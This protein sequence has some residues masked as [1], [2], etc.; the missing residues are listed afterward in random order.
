MLVLAAGIAACSPA[1]ATTP[2]GSCPLSGC[3]SLSRGDQRL[4]TGV[5]TVDLLVEPDDG[6]SEVVK[7][8]DGAQH[9]ILVSI[10]ILSQHRIV[11]ALERAATQGVAVYVLLERHPFGLFQQPQDE[12]AQLYA[13]G[14]HV[15]WAPDSFTYS[16]AK[17]MVL[18]DAVLI[19]ST[20]NF[21]KA[22]FTS[23]R[24]FVVVD[25]SPL[26]V[27]EA[28]NIFRADWD[29]IT[30]VLNDPNL[31]VSPANA[32]VK[33][34][35]LLGGATRSLDL[36]SE[37]MLDPRVVRELGA[38]A[39]SGV[40]VRVLAAIVPGWARRSLT[41]AGVAVARRAYGFRGVYIHAKAIVVDHR[42]AFVGSENISANSLDR[43]RELGVIIR[44]GAVIDRIEATFSEDW[45]A[46]R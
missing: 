32:R 6:V 19:L 12:F 29:R 43:N 35:R 21:S 41:Y 30:P 40:R 11:R 44:D 28:D 15:A 22:G 13:A 37:E 5:P 17:F 24:D 4:G 34:M 1:A 8:I 7:A 9:T 14:I 27:R 18:D 38:L 10:Y 16:H 31:V 42:L 3:S 2:R 36:Y 25:D 33:L 45:Q 20:A 46:A 26:D 39:R 23:D